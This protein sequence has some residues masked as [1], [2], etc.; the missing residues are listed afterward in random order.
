MQ[1]PVA[2]TF[3]QRP[4]WSASDWRSMQLRPQATSGAV[5]TGAQPPTEHT[6]IGVHT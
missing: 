3:P 5:H 6:S 1:I 4:Q 2:Q